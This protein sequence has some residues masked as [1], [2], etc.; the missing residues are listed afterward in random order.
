MGTSIANGGVVDGDLNVF[1]VNNLKVADIGVLPVSPDC[2]TAYAA[3]MV[4]L[5]CATILG[6][7]VPPAL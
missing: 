3:F 6:A 5:R 1:G 2:N 7:K 4:G